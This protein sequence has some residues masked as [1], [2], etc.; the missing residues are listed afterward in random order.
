MDNNEQPRYSEAG[1]SARDLFFNVGYSAQF[2]VE[3]Q[4]KENFYEV[5]FGKLFPHI[6]KF[7]VLPLG[8]KDAVLRHA[9]ANPGDGLIRQIYVV[10]KDFDDLHGV[11][12]QDPRIFYTDD[13]C[14]EGALI[15]EDALV[16]FA[17]E[18]S[19]TIRR[20]EIQQRI[21]F[22]V[23][24]VKWLK[25][26]DRLFRAFYL[27]QKYK[28]PMKNCD[29]SIYSFTVKDEP[30]KLD[31]S[32][33]NG[34]ELEVSKAFVEFGVIDDTTLYRDLRKGA[35]GSARI[36]RK[37]ISGKCLQDLFQALLRHKKLLRG[38]VRRESLSIRLVGSSRL[39]RLH[40]FRSRVNRY[41]NTRAPRE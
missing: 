38:S 7:K 6:D 41:L 8:G 1:L 19:P 16:K 3:D 32:K 22:Q 5:L 35:F 24:M 9:A 23:V 40:H 21:D 33:I 20:A 11:M 29:L 37:H 31:D 18:E 39:Y 17:V 15:E 34:Y 12:V 25:Q 10:D 14:V 4:D 36:G 2:F 30:W 13:Y 27:V 28:V 26:L